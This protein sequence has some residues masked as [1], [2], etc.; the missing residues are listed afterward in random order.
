MFCWL[1]S[2]VTVKDERKEPAQHPQKKPVK[3]KHRLQSFFCC[4]SPQTK[5]Q[6][7]RSEP[8]LVELKPFQPPTPP[9]HEGPA[10]LGDIFPQVSD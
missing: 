1:V 6:Y 2:Q 9:Q 10:V 7:Y 8:E 5:G 4:L 3:W